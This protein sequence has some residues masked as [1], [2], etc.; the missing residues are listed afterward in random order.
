MLK[1]C[2]EFLKMQIS[3][4]DC[5]GV[6]DRVPRIVHTISKD[7]VPPLYVRAAVEAATGFEHRHKSDSTALEYIYE[8]CSSTLAE[9]YKCIKPPAF[10]ADLF[11]F[12]ALY[13][14]GGLY[15]DA[16]IIPLVE[17]GE[18][19][20]S[21]S[22]F[23]LGY[24]QAQGRM[25]IAHIGMQMK[26]LAGVPRNNISACMLEHI[27]ENV[28]KRRRFKTPLEFSGPQLL[29]YCYLKHPKDV[30]ITYVDTRGAAW[31][32]SGLRDGAKV[33]AYEKPASS[34]HFQEIVERDSSEEYNDMVKRNDIY[35]KSCAV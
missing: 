31:P 29:R 23:T 21:C 34:R 27:T 33:L 16:D 28:R 8:R 11:R 32:Y 4:P 22:E 5:T 2:N 35:T 14:D 15:I 12:C 19:Y 30:A 17:V 26:I 18:L 10:R 25:D 7:K 20:S 1:Y 3:R 6:R 24:D 13:A 9:V